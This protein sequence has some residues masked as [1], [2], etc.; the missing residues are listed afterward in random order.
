[1]Q[2]RTPRPKPPSANWAPQAPL[3]VFVRNLQLLQ[4]DLHDDWPHISLRSLADT[5][6][7]Q[8]Q[9]VKAIEWALYHLVT[10]WDPSTARD[11]LRPFFPPLEPLQSVN[12]R[13]ALFRVLSELKKQ[14]DLGKEV[15]LRKSMLDDCRGE[16]FE[17][18]LAV[19]S[20]AVLRKTLAASSDPGLQNVAMRL[21]LAPGLT[22]EE[23][24]LML[25][26][27]L[28]HRVSLNQI[29][30]RR[31]KAQ[32]T[33]EKFTQLLDLKKLQLN[34]R[35][36]ESRPQLPDN[37]ADIDALARNLKE[38]WLGNEDWADALLH[39]GAPG[40]N[41]A[42]LELPFDTAWA[43]ANE[44][45]VDG[46][47]VNTSPDLLV[48]LESRVFRQR[49][50]LQRWRQYSASMRKHERVESTSSRS[51][52]LV[53]REHQAL[54]VAS[55]SKAVR[56]PVERASPKADDRALLFAMTESIARINGRSAARHR[57]TK[58]DSRSRITTT[59]PSS[60]SAAES[61][62]S[63]ADEQD[64][65]RPTRRTSTPPIPEPQ[66][67]LPSFSTTQAPERPPSPSEPTSRF[68]LVER[69]RKSMSLIPPPT[70]T[71]PRESFRS[72]RPR[73]SFP[74]NQFETPQKPLPMPRASTP[75]DELF[76]EEA[77]YASVFKSRPRVAHSPVTT[78]A[79]HIS[80][81][82]DFDL[83]AD[84]EVDLEELS[85]VD[86]YAQDTPLASRRR[87]L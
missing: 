68:T 79:V 84:E 57:H 77:D 60:F 37:G 10:L 40:S 85:E 62:S 71:R 9:R 50:R 49:A 14:G 3:S 53:F 4:L 26:L 78:P 83:G 64:T 20:T 43:K 70:H 36:K 17:E 34:E 45:S 51:Q 76:D 58:S 74:V 1:M 65:P 24:Q 75:R 18:L 46:L 5:S 38:N 67:D 6:Q 35:S 15:I 16:K 72:H 52:P 25:P 80:P 12:L 47:R 30:E 82:G 13:A 39:G 31:N 2:S 81:I 69:T 41:D 8:R 21:S 54:T 63:P 55:I 29:G 73:P 66:P 22:R 59:V 61:T 28:A 56:Q 48:D 7:N 19:F 32:D 42:F 27:V 44:S 23:Y 86:E 87:V 11:K 33:H